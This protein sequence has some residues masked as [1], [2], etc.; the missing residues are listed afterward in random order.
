MLKLLVKIGFLFTAAVGII[1]LLSRNDNTRPL[2]QE[3]VQRLQVAPE[4]TDLDYLFVGPSFTYAGLDPKQFTELGHSAF[5]LGTMDAGPWYCDLIVNDYIQTSGSPPKEILL[6]LSPLMFSNFADVWWRYPFHRY[7]NEPIS[8]EEVIWEYRPLRTVHRMYRESAQKGALNLVWSGDPQREIDSL[9]QQ[10][11]DRLGYTY[12][13]NGSDIDPRNTMADS[14]RLKPQLAI[15]KTYSQYL[16]VP[17][18]TPDYFS[19][20]ERWQ[21]QGIKVTIVEIPTCQTL[22]YYS[23]HF[24]E[25]YAQVK[26]LIAEK[27]IPFVAKQD[28]EHNPLYFGDIGHLNRYGGR[29]YTRYVIEKLGLNTG[30]R[31]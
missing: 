15:A 6:C 23:K 28:F 2:A 9:R 31:E 26:E 11:R 7:L 19:M 18:K 25:Q 10:L 30:N 16:F 12:N 22:P 21:Q 27:N 5:N 29:E 24:R 3:S 13:D 8:Q 20:I 14:N 17:R 4:Y 1:W